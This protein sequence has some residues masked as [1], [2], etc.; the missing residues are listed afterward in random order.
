MGILLVIGMP[1]CCECVDVDN[2][3]V[4]WKLAVEYCLSQELV[5]VFFGLFSPAGGCVLQVERLENIV[6]RLR[7][8]HSYAIWGRDQCEAVVRE[9]NTVTTHII[10]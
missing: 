5:H 10:T 2:C 1:Q 8:I 7:R 3:P 4:G 6:N 9:T